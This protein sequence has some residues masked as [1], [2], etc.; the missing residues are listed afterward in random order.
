MTSLHATGMHF[1]DDHSLLRNPTDPQRG[2]GGGG[3]KPITFPFH[4]AS[5]KPLS[6][7]SGAA[8]GEQRRLG[9]PCFHPVGTQTAA[10]RRQRLFSCPCVGRD[11][12]QL[13]G[14]GCPAA[15]DGEGLYPKKDVFPTWDMLLSVHGQPGAISVWEP[16]VPGKWQGT[17]LL[18]SVTRTPAEPGEGSQR[19]DP[20]HPP[21]P[22]SSPWEC[23]SSCQT[24]R[25][26]K[27]VRVYHFPAH[28]ASLVSGSGLCFWGPL[29]TGALHTVSPAPGEESALG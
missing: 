12:R 14:R 20:Q 28:P 5:G 11:C 25:T 10:G 2:A 19:W 4:N 21:A 3:R 15:R 27:D 18:A 23:F 22:L 1:R 26:C 29:F 6:S 8:P 17:P 24:H 13:K 9:Q 7:P 16:P